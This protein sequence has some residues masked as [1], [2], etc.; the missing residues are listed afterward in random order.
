MLVTKEE[1]PDTIK[2]SSKKVQ[3]TYR[4]ALDSAHDQYGG[5]EERAHR[6][7]WGAV[8]NLAEK[9]GDHWE[10][11]GSTGPSDPRSKKSQSEKRQ[12]KGETFQGVDVEGN[13]KE[14]LAKRAQRAGISGTSDMD[15][16]EIARELAKKGG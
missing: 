13:T 9:K 4:K 16:K 1:M 2:R 8:K 14:E 6:T 12:G 5:D 11:K 15:K 3:D 7:A 10:L